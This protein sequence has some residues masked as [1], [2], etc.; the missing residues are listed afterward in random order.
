MYPERG[1]D[2]IHLPN[3]KAEDRVPA[4]YPLSLGPFVCLICLERSEIVLF[5]AVKQVLRHVQKQ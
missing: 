2:I 1:R 5:S 3:H 4:I